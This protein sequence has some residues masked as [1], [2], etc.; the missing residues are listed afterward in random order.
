MTVLRQKNVWILV[1][2]SV[3]LAVLLRLFIWLGVGG[4]QFTLVAV[5][6]LTE[7]CLGSAQSV[8]CSLRFLNIS[9]RHLFETALQVDS[10][11]SGNLG[12]LL[13]VLA[14]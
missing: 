11:G 5:T 6:L 7:I 13:G 1:R 2:D 8:N 14:S 3:K 12:C 10:H 9:C 4:I